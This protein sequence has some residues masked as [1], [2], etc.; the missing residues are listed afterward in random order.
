MSARIVVTG[1][2]GMVGRFL[3]DQ[4]RRQGRQV[5]ALTSA[6]CDITD[7][8]APERF[9]AAG[10]VVVNCAAFTQVDLAEANE[11]RAYAVNAAGAGNVAQACARAGAKL[12]HISTDYVFSGV[13]DGEPRPYEIDDPTG[14][15]GVYGKSKLAGEVAVLAALPDAHI[16]R[17]AWIYQGSPEGSDFVAIMRRLAAG[18]GTVD[19]VADQVGCPTYVGDLVS[20][21]L[22]I[23]DGAIDGPVLHAANIGAVSRFEQA[24][25]VFEGVGADPDRVRPCGTDRHPRPAPRPMYSALSG[26]K[27]AKAGLAPLRPWR[28]GLTEALTVSP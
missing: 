11:E 19:V 5:L 15:L 17:T 1:A 23:A 26:A 24:R 9:V 7:P 20:A 13:F 6:Q 22:Q 16:V 18:N 28:E 3:A 21:L 8:G 27:S 25:A 10:D 14:P 12:V 2:G 4:G